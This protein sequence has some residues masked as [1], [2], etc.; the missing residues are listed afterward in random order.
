MQRAACQLD[1]SVDQL[2]QLEWLREHGACSDPRRYIA[3]GV[4]GGHDDYGQLGEAGVQAHQLS[5]AI[6][7]Q[8]RHHQVE[9]DDVRKPAVQHVECVCA[10][11][12]GL[13]RTA[14]LTQRFRDQPTQGWFIVHYKHSPLETHTP[15]FKPP[16]L[17]SR[18]LTISCQH[19]AEFVH[20]RRRKLVDT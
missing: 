4:R 14:R 6:A 20:P 5:E 13:H 9:N 18:A 7:V 17:F 11:G 15:H 3:S 19:L 8:A 10:I 2:L 16:D 12:C 1:N